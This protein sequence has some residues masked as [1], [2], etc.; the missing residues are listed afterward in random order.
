M[1][2]IYLPIGALLLSASLWAQEPQGRTASTIVADVLAQ[3]PAQQT[4]QYYAQIKDLASTGEEGA[5]H[6]L[7][8][9]QKKVDF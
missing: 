1:K 7:S 2:K 8:L 9:L 5:F 4:E 6:H 3:M